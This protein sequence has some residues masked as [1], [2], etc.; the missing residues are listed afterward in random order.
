MTNP[1]PKLD[2]E[3]KSVLDETEKT[4]TTVEG[5]PAA[6]T[7][8]PSW[9]AQTYGADKPGELAKRYRTHVTND[10]PETA[11]GDAY[12]AY[13]RRLEARFQAAKSK[14]EPLAAPARAHH[15]IPTR[16]PIP[17]EPKP[18]EG[19]TQF[20]QWQQ[21]Q[22]AA[23]MATRPTSTRR[24]SPMRTAGLLVMACCVGG[25]AGFATTQ[26]ENLVKLGTLAQGAA[27]TVG[28]RLASLFPDQPVNAEAQAQPVVAASTPAP[29]TTTL[30][31][32]PIKMA[33]LDVTDVQ[34]ALNNPIPLQL[35]ASSE[36]PDVPLAIKITG[37]PQSAYLTSGTEIAA[38][39]WLL[40]PSEIANVN[41]VVPTSV[42]PVLD[43]AVAAVE[44]KTGTP[45]APTQALTV[46]LDLANAQV[47]PANAAPEIQGQVPQPVPLPDQTQTAALDD[48]LQ[49]GRSMMDNGDILSA[50][51]FFE[52]AHAQGNTAAAYDNVFAEMNVR[53]LAPDKAKAMEWYQL[54]SQAGSAEAQDAMARL[55]A[56]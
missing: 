48:L 50:R 4:E 16:R 11:D 13:R 22:H 14:V 20:R 18:D 38:G 51:Q 33:R 29:T 45:A 5:S 55:T 19:Q 41:L 35:E 31:K 53:G 26:T 40:K 1:Q 44:A 54:A 52:T 7:A 49:K 8:P 24:M 21:R 34:G 37:L 42:E 2:I 9:F 30:T 39:E 25:A 3:L 27:W 36:N 43:L 10:L 15:E 28:D 46:E 56:Q 32:K 17:S 12:E 23:E 6:D 47:L